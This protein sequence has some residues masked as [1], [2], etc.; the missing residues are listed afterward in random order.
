[1]P[2]LRLAIS[3]FRDPGQRAFEVTLHLVPQ[4]IKL[5]ADLPDPVAA[6]ITPP[7]CAHNDR[8]GDQADERTPIHHPERAYIDVTSDTRILEPCHAA[9]DRRSPVA[10]ALAWT[11][12]RLGLRKEAIAR[13]NAGET[14][15]GHRSELCRGSRHDLPTAG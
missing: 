4:R 10:Q 5:H 9:I 14:A 2:A 8:A 11:Q 1:M 15:G 13:R 6:G 3:D 7:C 12:E